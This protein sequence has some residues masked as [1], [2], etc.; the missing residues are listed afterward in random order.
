LLY[1]HIAELKV[2]EIVAG[3]YGDRNFR[4]DDYIPRKKG[5]IIE[6]KASDSYNSIDISSDVCVVN[7]AEG[8]CIIVC[9]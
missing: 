8:C 9:S 5:L 4:C 6:M 7:V 2:K 3:T 1:N